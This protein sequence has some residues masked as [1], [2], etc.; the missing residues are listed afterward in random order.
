MLLRL[1]VGQ[2]RP[3]SGVLRVAGLEPATN[4]GQLYQ[5]VGFLLS[6]DGLY[7]RQSARSNLSFYGRLYGLPNQRVEQVLEQV[8]L[9]DHAEVQAE[10]LSSPLRRRLAYGRAILHQP[11]VFILVDPFIRCD[12]TSISFLSRLI[13]ALASETNADRRGAAILIL[14]ENENHLTR[15]CQVINRIDQGRISE[16][17]R[18]LEKPAAA[19]PFKI[20]LPI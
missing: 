4:R 17:E 19:M 2:E 16:V 5:R 12:E 13:H 1:L 14:C 6:E 20:H 15:L 7:H 3:S 18:P 11:Q 8:G 9:T 10:K